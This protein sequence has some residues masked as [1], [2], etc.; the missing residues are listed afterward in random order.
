[1]RGARGWGGGMQ[2]GSGLGQPQASGGCHTGDMPPTFVGL[3]G[4]MGLTWLCHGR[5]PH[6]ADADRGPRDVPRLLGALCFLVWAVEGGMFQ[7]RRCMG[8]LCTFC[9][10]L[11]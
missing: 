10:A 1:M 5:R 8:N 2:R 9:S 11:P 6:V 4:A 7:G 3:Q